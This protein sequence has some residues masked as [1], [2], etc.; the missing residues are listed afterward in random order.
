[1]P[2]PLSGRSLVRRRRI[3]SV[4]STVKDTIDRYCRG[5]SDYSTLRNELAGLRHP[6]AEERDFLVDA[7]QELRSAGR[8]SEAEYA[9]LSPLAGAVSAEDAAGHDAQ[10]DGEDSRS[11]VVL[12][13]TV[14]MSQT[15]LRESVEREAGSADGSPGAREQRGAGQSARRTRSPRIS[16]PSS[17]AAGGESGQGGSWA[18][19]KYDKDR[20]VPGVGDVLKER[21]VLAKRVGQGGMGIVFKTLDLRKEEAQDRNPYLALKILSEEFK[22]HPDSL[23]ALQ[24]EAQKSQRLAHPNVVNVFDFDRDGDT[25]YMT[26][27]FLDGTPLDWVIKHREAIQVTTAKALD[28]IRQMSAGLAYAHARGVV[29][30]DFKPGNVFLTDEGVIKILDFGIARATKHIGRATSDDTLFDARTLGALTPNYASY[31]MFAGEDPHPCDDIYALGCTAYELL[32]GR[33]PYDRTPAIDALA[34]GMQPQP[35]TNI[36]R[37]QWRAIASALALKREDRVAT[38]E[39]FLRLLDEKWARKWGLHIAA[40]ATAAVLVVAVGLAI[41][42]QLRERQ[43]RQLGEQLASEQPDLVPAALER[44]ARLDL[45]D[46]RA[47]LAAN[48]NSLLRFFDSRAR[49]A[50]SPAAGRY[51]YRAA[52][53]QLERALALYAFNDAAVQVLQGRLDQLAASRNQLLN[54]LDSRFNSSLEAFEGGDYAAADEIFEVLDRVEEVD[55]QHPLLSDGRLPPAFAAVARRAVDAGD[56]DQARELLNAIIPSFPDNTALREELG[57]ADLEERRVRQAVEVFLL[58]AEVARARRDATDVDALPALGTVAARLRELDPGNSELELARRQASRVVGDAVAPLLAEFRFDDARQLVSDNAA[59][60]GVGSIEALSGTIAAAREARGERLAGLMTGLREAAAAGDIGSG[61]AAEQAFA[62]LKE[63]RA[64]AALE[65]QARAVLFEAYIREANR[66]R[67]DADWTA[68][69]ALLSR[70]GQYATS[71]DD[72]QRLASTSTLIDRAASDSRSALARAERERRDEERLARVSGLRQRFEAALGG[73]DPQQADLESALGIIDEIAAIDPANP[74]VAEGRESVAA[75]LAQRAT[76]LREAGEYQAARQVVSEGMELLPASERLYD[77]LREIRAQ[78]QNAEFRAREQRIAALRSEIDRLLGDAAFTPTWNRQLR[79][80]VD[81][82]EAAGA[83]NVEESVALRA[84]IAGLFADAAESA[85]TESRFADARELIA[86]GR[87]YQSDYPRW[88]RELGLIARGEQALVR[89]SE[90]QAQSARVDGL[91]QTLRTQSQALDV[92]AAAETLD[93]LR[94]LVP[95]DSYVVVEA[96][97]LLAGAYVALAELALD[98][99]QYP[100]AESLAEQGLGYA[101]SDGKLQRVRDLARRERTKRA[102]VEA[103][104]GD[105][106][107]SPGDVAGMLE[108]LRALA[109]SAYAGDARVMAEEIAARLDRLADSDP[110]RAGLLYPQAIRYFPNDPKLRALDL[111]AARRP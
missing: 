47:I 54:V 88:E 85:R 98:E 68:A 39:E 104:S 101:P 90:M 100:R 103:L 84:R 26:M 73:S 49:A 21:F 63:A 74:L 82:L 64:G 8:L 51:D 81:A 70:A 3:P 48:S 50:F 24:R 80:R 9:E 106:E 45:P 22:Q 95:D 20:V 62:A 56:Y 92:R 109:G 42:G 91:K 57:R 11:T 53:A 1:M 15:E 60:L 19:L 29:H 79:D 44:V 55:P 41:P 67:T 105:G 25:V 93:R 102:V 17:F 87:S 46:R 2:V 76:A 65:Q 78:E 59:Y 86:A 13:R 107:H 14:L 6:S 27:E 96:P 66:L 16:I 71:D 99:R 4:V 72:R 12:Q 32:S 58:E 69:R 40:A 31:E 61:S 36:T 52:R 37:S 10:Q 110:A 23:K 35:L 94:D 43:L 97:A 111:N 18:D 77:E 89:R 108:S 34:R 30:A 5:E 38:I 28:Y 7:L 33:H 83:V 75:S